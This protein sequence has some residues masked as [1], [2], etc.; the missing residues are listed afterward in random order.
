MKR[1]I[2]ELLDQ[3]GITVNGSAPWDIQVKHPQFYSRLLR[4]TDLAL[5]ESYMDGWWD[6]AHL[7]QFFYRVLKAGL[8]NKVVS[9]SIFWRNKLFQSFYRLTYHLFNQQTYEKALAV[10]KQHYDVGNDLYQIMLDPR[11]IYTCGYWETAE[12]LPQAQEDKLTLTCDKLKL[13]PGM[14]VLDIGCG[15]G[16]LAKFMAQRY[17]VSVVGVTISK[18]QVEWGRK[19]CQGLPVKILFQD[20]RELLKTNTKYDRVVS[21]GMF[22]HV[23]Y[24]NYGTYM[25]VVSHCLKEGGLFLLHTIG[26]NHSSPVTNAWI[27]KYIFPH[28][29]LPSIAQIG[30]AVE[31]LFV[32]EDWHNFGADYDRTL[33]AWYDNFNRGWAHLKDRYDVRFRRMWNFYLLSCAAT[34]R[35][36]RN[37]LWQIVFSKK[38]IEGGYQRVLYEYKQ[39][40]SHQKV[41][42]SAFV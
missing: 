17:K 36:R 12:N 30:S 37:Q 1:V 24:K 11:M 26:A 34:F 23:G 29:H 8:D 21:L 19:A 4:N 16:G 39:N 14:K 31:A 2:L 38:G 27:N 15:W 25:K 9:S 18:Q 7:D 35:A 41:R 20:Y 42:Q 6:C 28:G 3:A 32:M 13:Q 5:G 33:M 22:E 10:G 40:T